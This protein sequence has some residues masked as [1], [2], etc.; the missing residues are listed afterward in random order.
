MS[1]QY[2]ILVKAR[3]GAITTKGASIVPSQQGRNRA[4]LDHQPQEVEGGIASEEG[5]TL[6]QEDYFAYSVERIRA[7]NKNLPSHD[8]EIEGDS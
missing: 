8:T 5:S 2:T 4:P 1:E 7:N 3:T 6:N